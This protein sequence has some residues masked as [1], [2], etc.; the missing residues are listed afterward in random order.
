L[1][2]FIRAYNATPPAAIVLQNPVL[3]LLITMSPVYA[4]IWIP[5]AVAILATGNAKL[6]FLGVAAWAALGI[7]VLAGVKFY[8]AVPALILFSA[9]GAN[10]WERWT[11][12]KF[13]RRSVVLVAIVMLSGLLTVP[14]AAPVLPAGRLQDIANYLRNAEAGQVLEEPAGL[15][16]YFPHFAEMHGWPEL[17]ALTAE[18]AGR[19][20]KIPSDELLIVAAHY[21]QAAAL[22]RLDHDG[23]LPVAYS[24]HM[25]YDLWNRQVDF[26]R[27]L[28]VGFTA[29]ELQ[30]M[31]VVVE[32]LG[33]MDCVRCMGRERALRIF[34]VDEPKLTNAEIRQRIRRYYFF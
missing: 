13:G 7:F 6:R 17:V 33:S 1:L 8:F 25:S 22:N 27:G 5:G 9:I 16:R 26:Q 2:D 4:L 31:F 12:R 10:C 20:R 3:G 28:F 14:I 18:A 11:G 34:F 24:G 19:Q 30:T 32:H 15:E 21:G 23:L 29:E